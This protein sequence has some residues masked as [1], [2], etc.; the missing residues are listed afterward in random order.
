M[1]SASLSESAINPGHDVPFEY[2]PL[3]ERQI[4]LLQLDPASEEKDELFGKL[5]VKS[6]DDLPPRMRP[7][8]VS[9]VEPID[10]EKHVCFQA[11]SYVWGEA[12]LTD[13]FHTPQGP[14]SITTSLGSILRR[15][16]DASISRLYWADG[17]CINQFDIT[18][19]EVQISLMG[20][21]YSSAVRV[22]CDIGEETE[23]ISL[24]LDAMTRYW[25]RN[26]RHG[27]VLGQ[28]EGMVLSG[29][30]TAKVMGL[31]FPIDEE[32]DAIEDVEGDEW[33][34]RFVELIS[35]PWFHRLW[36]VQEFVLGRDVT[37]VFGRRQ[38][39]WGELW[40]GTV[41][42][43]GVAWPWDSPDFTPEQLTTLFMSYN[44][45][46]LVRLC[47]TIDL[48]TQH[49]REFAKIVK[50]LLCGIEINKANLSMC[51]I[52]F[53]SHGCTVPRDRYLGVLG[54]IDEEDRKESMDLRPDYTSPMRDITMRFWT[55][56][57]R[58]NSGG[59][60]MLA[61]GIPGQ[62]EGW[63]SWLRDLSAPNPLSHIWIGA[64]LGTAWHQAGGPSDTWSAV[65]RDDDP[66]CLFTKGFQIDKI[67][68]DP[69]LS[70]QQPFDLNA[71]CQWLN[72]ASTFY[73]SSL[74]TLDCEADMR[75][76]PTGEHIHEAVLKSACDYNKSDT[77]A[78]GSKKFE[79]I[80]RMGL[81]VPL[82]ATSDAIGGEDMEDKI[83]AAYESDPTTVGELF[84]RVY[85][86][87]GMCFFKTDKGLITLF[88]KDARPGDSIWIFKGCR[89][90]VV[91]RPCV[92]HPGTFEF[93]GGGYVH[94]L[95]NGEVFC[96]PGFKWKGVCL[97]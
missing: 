42:Y 49:G 89:L 76:P 32:T 31:Q 28:G 44:A 81:S 72:D 65:F 27:Y 68:G 86:G 90:P 5:L 34:S 9:D 2:I 30:A 55:Y 59:E 61:A 17:I 60:L 25:K 14:I 66:D 51:L 11:I 3:G 70:A 94:G 52:F 84:L 56:A 74:K 12:T 18:E 46:C 67:S 83:L 64:P 92:S 15:L 96:R 1:S 23:T 71:M 69:S 75:Y 62:V 35:R 29:E 80:L 26:I 10:P 16:R 77:T 54:M 20:I 47:R 63:P 50:I 91:L 39:P 41:W 19:K 36:V 37:M 48:S 21:I 58:F 79:P 78:S 38:I 22:V 24:T 88:Y 82:V 43:D 85:V 95:M 73:T 40:A 13:T 33:S 45:M 87:R 57:L 8:H 53:S 6:L 7:G 4:R 93:V 97:R